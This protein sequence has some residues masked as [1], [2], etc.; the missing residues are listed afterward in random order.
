MAILIL[1]YTCLVFFRLGS[2]KAPQTYLPLRSGGTLEFTFS[3]Q[4]AYMLYYPGP[5]GTKETQFDLWVGDTANRTVAEEPM[6][7]KQVFSCQA[8]I[9]PKES[10]NALKLRLLDE[11]AILFELVFMDENGKV[12]LPDNAAA[13]EKLFDETTL[14]PKEMSTQTEAF[15]DEAY[16]AKAGFEY[17]HH[18]PVSE[19]T[20]PPFGK[21]LITCSIA[22]FGMNPFGWRFMNALFGILIIPLI[23]SFLSKLTKNEWIG[24]FGATLYT[25]DFMHFAESRIATLD[26]F[27]AFFILLMYER[28]LA[29]CLA[30]SEG[31]SWKE[32]K[33]YLLGGAIATA[34]AVA[35]KWTG[36]FAGFGLAVMFLIIWIRDGRVKRIWFTIASYL[37][38]TAGVYLLSYLPQSSLPDPEAGFFGN[39]LTRQ[40]QILGF[41]TTLSESHPYE[42]GWL[43]WPFMNR[44]LLMVGYPEEDVVRTHMTFGNPLI[45]WGGLAALA[46]VLVLSIVDL[47]KKKDPAFAERGIFLVVSYLAQYLPWAAVSRATFIYHYFP[48]VAFLVAALSLL[49]MRLW[50]KAGTKKATAFMVFLSAAAIALFMLFYPVLSGMRISKSYVHR[51][52]EWGKRW[53]MTGADSVN[54]Q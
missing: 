42:S 47:A 43:E 21:L 25:F 18:L 37:G 22:L 13:F 8:R 16:Y 4:P 20:H 52:L 48:C 6:Q 33:R 40:Q 51:T 36:I 31:V 5:G 41:H 35:T 32:Q 27:C 53:D 9:L 39:F 19:L 2:T 44:P 46:L 34:L 17:L 3:R 26:I 54:T 7:M 11:R 49:A 1:L 38:I 23:F 29:W 24:A 10:W 15:F 28:F 12:I 14:L 30:K 50:E 45:W